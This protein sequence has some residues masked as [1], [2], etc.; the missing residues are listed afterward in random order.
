MAVADVD[1][2]VVLGLVVGRDGGV[3]EF[4]HVGFKIQLLNII[5]LF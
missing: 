4:F 5:L 1:V 3:A 2:V